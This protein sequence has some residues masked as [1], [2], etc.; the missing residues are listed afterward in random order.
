[1]PRKRNQQL[2]RRGAIYQDQHGRPWETV[3]DTQAMSTCQAPTAYRWSA[4]VYPPP[5]YFQEFNDKPL[6]FEINYAKWIDDLEV[7]AREY[8]SAC[9][10]LGR[11]MN[12]DPD[13]PQVRE[14][15]GRP[16]YPAD[17]AKACR[18][19][20]NWALGKTKDW[21]TRFP[22]WAEAFKEFWAPERPKEMEFADV[23][24]S[25]VPDEKYGVYEEMHDPEGVGGQRPKTHKMKEK[26]ST[27][28]VA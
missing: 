8:R 22:K 3:F 12:L 26:V 15:L 9:V 7:R 20:N 24:F 6:I 27:A 23:E 19:G 16:P 4:P 2:E 28:N 13:A 17:L 14:I 5:A 21:E 18:A 10:E 1:V 25:D 11:K